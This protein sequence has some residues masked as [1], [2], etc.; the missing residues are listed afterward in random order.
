MPSN[1][2][3]YIRH[4]GTYLKPTAKIIIALALLP[5]RL[6]RNSRTIKTAND[7]VED[8]EITVLASVAIVADIE[9]EVLENSLESTPIIEALLED[10]DP[11]V[12]P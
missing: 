6:I 10:L 4:V 8:E 7:A 9:E 11:M 3:R 5:I 2:I 1:L 12:L